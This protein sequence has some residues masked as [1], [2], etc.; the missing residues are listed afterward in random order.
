MV[1]GV[2]ACESKPPGP[3][4]LDATQAQPLEVLPGQGFEVAVHLTNAT[5]APARDVR[6]EEVFEGTPSP[7]AEETV[8]S[9]EAG[10]ER[11][12]TFRL[13]APVVA[14]R[15]E[16]EPADTY[17][18]RLEAL[19]RQRLLS[20]GEVRFADAQGGPTQS[21]SLSSTS[22][23]VL[24]RLSLRVEGPPQVVPG[25]PVVYTL[26]V[27][28]PGTAT[29]S[30]GSLKVQLPDETQV[31]VHLEALAPGA[32]WSQEVS[33]TVPPLPAR[34]PGEAPAEYAARLRAMDGQER[35][36]R[37]ELSWRDSQGNTYGALG[38]ET[39][40]A[41]RVDVP[42]SHVPP[43]PE[44]V[45][46]P[47]PTLS[48]A[49]FEDSTSF[50]Y[51]GNNPIQ[52]GVTPGTLEPHR[53]SVLRGKVLSRRGHPLAEVRVSVLDHPEYGHTSTREDGLFDL[54]VNGGGPLTLRYEAE[55][56]LPSQRQAQVPRG[57][58]TWLPDVV[59]IALDVQGTP[60]DFSGASDTLQVARGSPVSDA[61]GTRQATLLFPPGT[62]ALAVLPNGDE[63][64]LYS[65]TVRATEYT[66]G[67]GGPAAMP[68]HLP[69][70]SG[71]TYAVELTLD[72][73]LALN[74]QEVRFN[75][76]VISYVDNFLGFPVGGRVPAGYYDRQ[77]GLWL[78]STGGRIIQ[79]LSILDGV[80]Q[81]DVT[82]D[83]LPADPYALS[84][85]NIT[86]AEQ[87]QLASLYAVGK[88]LWRVP[89]SHFT[90]WD[91]N[92]PYGPPPG[93][94]PPTN[95]P[96]RNRPDN[97]PDCQKGSVIDCQ[98]QALGESI[99][100][101]GTPFRLHYRSDRVPGP[102]KNTLSIAVSGDSVPP[103]LQGIVVEVNVAGRR[104]TY[105]LPATPH[106]TL[107]FTWDGK[108]AYG[109]T[110]Q[111]EVP[112]TGRTGYV[113]PLV[114][115]KPAEFFE[116][117]ALLGSTPL[118]S[119][120]QE[121]EMTLWQS[122]DSWLGGWNESPEALGGWRLSVHHQAERRGDALF[123]GHGERRPLQ[124][125][126]SPIFT[127]A[128]TGT[129][130]FGG[131]GGPATSAHLNW[132]S[133]VAVGPDGA[134][135]IADTG[136]QRIR[137]VG[138]G[139]TISTLAG[140]GAQGPAL[141]GVPATQAT[142]NSPRAVAVGL[143]GSVYI[144]DSSNNKVRRVDSN[145]IISDVAGTGY[146]SQ[147]QDGVSS[148][149]AYLNYPTGVAVGAD[150]SVYIADGS[151]WR[152]RL[153][154][155]GPYIYHMAGTGTRGYGGDG[156]ASTQAPINMPNGVAVGPDGSVYI[157]DTYN[158][159]I[160]RVD[161]AGIIT[162]VAGSG[163]EGFAGDGGPA[164]QAR[165]YLPHSVA[166]GPDGSLYIA[167]TYNHRIRHVDTE[168]TISTL[169]GTGTMGYGGDGGPATQATLSSPISL[170]LGPDGSLY[171]ADLRNNR[172]RAIRLA[173]S[174]ASLND[175]AVTAEDGREL[176]VFGA[177]GRHLRTEDSLTGA[178]RYRFEYDAAGRLSSLTEG[179][180]LVTR[181]ER[182]A[183]GR[184]L[185]I[186]AP[187]GQRTRL[188]LDARGYLSSVTNPEGETVE[189]QHTSNGL[190]TSMRDARG[191]LHQYH[192]DAGG[193]LERDIHPSGGFKQLKRTDTENG[194]TVDLSTAL[195][196]THRYQVQKL[197]GG[198]E[199]RTH[200]APEGTVTVRL[201]TADSSTLTSTM[202]DGTV[203]TEVLGPDARFGMQAPLLS[204]WQ[205]KLPGGLTSRFTHG[206]AVT[207]VNGDST[208]GVSTL[209]DTLSRNGQPF[210]STYTA[211]N[212]TLTRRSPE[213]RQ[214]IATLD[215][216]GRLVRQEVSGVLPMEYSHDA[217][218]RITKVTQ[219]DRTETYTYHPT[220]DLAS[221]V[222][223]LQRT[224]DFGYN[225]AGRL[226]SQRFPGG[227]TVELSSDAHG[228]LTRLVPPGR[229]GHDFQYTPSDT[230]R[231]Y[232]PPP[233]SPSTPLPGTQYHY[234]LDE[235]LTSVTLPD[236]SSVN[237]TRDGA[238]RVERLTT[239]RT[240][241]HFGYDPQGRLAALTDSAGP[242]LAFTHDGPLLK[243]V[244]WRGDVNG[245]VGY[246][247][248]PDFTHATLD[249]H[250][251]S[252][253]LGY[254][255]DGLL[256]SAGALS[257]RR[258]QDNGQLSATTLARVTTE[259]Q[260]NPHGEIRT[261]SASVGSTALYS[262]TLGRDL[263]GRIVT[264]TEVA[265][266]VTHAWGYA[267]DQE[268]RLQDVTR[269][270]AHYASYGY[271]LNGNRTALTQAGVTL[272]ATHDAQDRLHTQGGATYAFGPNGDLQQRLRSSESAPTQYVYDSLGAL[273]HVQL[274]DG[275]RV[276]YVLD[277][278]GRRVGKRLDGALVQGFLYDGPL[279]VVAELDGTGA[280]VS[281]FVYASQR[282]VPD[283]MIRQGVTYRLLSDHLGSI[284]LVVEAATGSVAQVLEY[285]PFGEVLSDSHPGFQPFAFA[286][287][288][289]D[290]H[291]GLTRFGVRD[292]D[293]ETGRWTA[294]DPLLFA[295]GQLNLY[296]YAMGDPVNRI[297]PTGLISVGFS[298]Y[299]GA[300]FGF[301]LS[302][303]PGEGFSFC[304][305]VGFGV[306]G[307]LEVKP[308][309]GLADPGV[310]IK[311]EVTS[312]A[313][314]AK[315]KWGAEF[316]NG[317]CGPRM[318][319]EGGLGVGPAFMSFADGQLSL[320]PS[321]DFGIQ[322][323]ATLNAKACARL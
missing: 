191:G 306:G 115:L 207:Y 61:D 92:W 163:M 166:V 56:L 14:A 105:P 89:V 41:L 178:P 259:Q 83:G 31:E 128:G 162:T 226:S 132:P 45:A 184:P 243:Q 74:S 289:H 194:H 15:T 38:E 212:R 68:A 23:L 145:G 167:D 79:V 232:T 303:V 231:G 175:A 149:S 278:S 40:A 291:S 62:R 290:A 264:K 88:S 17:L 216:K 311:A 73:A 97:K 188:T 64:P 57:D 54:A 310:A 125:N 170:A 318:K 258:G 315:M 213:G 146:A 138:A 286:G 180:G 133:G 8:G 168:G 225:R 134:L 22:R 42:A 275:T 280:V 122:W 254:D 25:Q 301:E 85:L 93:S 21:L 36:T 245:R 305:Q 151:N 185:A 139:G 236:R 227:R 29:A 9:L 273:T 299:A 104:F 111:G 239:P 230:T 293:A 77:R 91:Y 288:L 309:G 118:S 18:R 241:V 32:T 12:V 161:P 235:A 294:R 171:V 19:E 222:D 210:L 51:T 233:P 7:S 152:V 218:G 182:D 224:T 58:F 153:A 302:W 69:T 219:G 282:H 270:G 75:Q 292:Y 5:S 113:Y 211:A 119:N 297:D 247:H 165:L 1:V 229:P 201:L 256:T 260:Y 35:R 164:T 276:D 176:H 66:V 100:V 244:E 87:R 205:V 249:I 281:R 195:G 193:R 70:T 109:R 84:R 60:V 186:V 30:A 183:S 33:W 269:D 221:V 107:T 39:A 141:D 316:E 27:S 220:G 53:L 159:R 300:G 3:V 6:V 80:A 217:E 208:Q 179:E 156:G 196:A 284:R 169:A 108:D 255:H 206:N 154:G 76:P 150:G 317:K 26:T 50:I 143:D 67:E 120:R 261:M 248:T 102:D 131:E 95:R 174:T 203:S 124:A 198:G 13:T 187:H 321:S 238:G 52:T 48:T 106:Q 94:R 296:Q 277:A 228:N 103:S 34:E 214:S 265:Q 234:N 272:S 65:A 215:E 242:S 253:A 257:L 313:L 155:P 274:P 323:S 204:S 28:N 177:G 46:P 320:E 237:V 130:G 181:V 312:S 308:F 199:K 81:L 252:I 148:R 251:Q 2:L 72:E 157:A 135:Y 189:L 298:A 71:Y 295:G 90:P 197:P 82:G 123:L 266:G 287:G 126:K 262:F 136:N 129:E 110:V 314:W 142:F 43:H 10:E 240:S 173:R 160:R 304:S 192:Y 319:R 223:V 271:D 283:Y 96:P 116:S 140:T 78:P 20:R 190:L 147:S 24:P 172:I 49:S 117:F 246:T 209:E 55:G 267:Y 59:M 112:V 127:V 4:S 158:H 268:G 63:V 101:T 47:L 99:P 307:G 279:R 86:E 11:T 121:R 114:Y 250:G 44:D 202:P 144:A 16:G 285:G 98:N 263:A 137:R 322:Q 37:A 200:T